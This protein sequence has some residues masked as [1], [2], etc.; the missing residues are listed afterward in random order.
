MKRAFEFS[1][2]KS[3][4]FWWME[5][6]EEKFV[7]NYGKIDSIGKYEIKEWDSIEECEKQAEKLIKSKI[8]KGYKEINNFDFENRYYFDDMEYDIDFLTSHPNFR[9]H[10]T[11]E[12]LYCNCGDEET[13]FGSDTGNDVLHIIEEKIRKNKNFSFSDFPKYLIEKEWGIEYFEPVPIIDEKTFAEELKI[14]DKGLSREAII[15]QSDEVIIATAF[16]QIKITGKISEDLK[17]RALLSLKRMEL[18][19]KICGYGES[20]INK[21]LYNDLESFTN[22]ENIKVPTY[23]RNNIKDYEEK[24]F[25]TM[26][27]VSSSGNDLLEV[28]YCGELF[29]VK[30]EKTKYIGNIDNIP[31][32]ILAIDRESKE[33]IIIFDESS[34]GYNS[35]FCDEYTDDQIKNRTLKK[36]DIPTSKLILEL[37]YNIDYEDEKEEF[38]N[39][40]NKTVTLI[41]G[42][43]ISWEDVK[44]NGYDFLRL[45]YINNNGEKISIA[46]YELA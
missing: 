31:I 9:K 36:Y 14:K 34:H 44:V 19:A 22:K 16:A 7:V 17:E 3:H 40:D 46:E 6:F 29:E 15:N 45:S 24:T 43:I 35:M 25:S 11:D 30:G 38:I 2:E 42:D 12:Q 39:E 26:T 23:L 8:K 10:F 20:E 41:N 32:K 33:E 21:Q 37:G 1:D 4:K 27:I 28:W 18:I 13:P 5:S